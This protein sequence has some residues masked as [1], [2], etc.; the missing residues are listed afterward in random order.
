MVASSLRPGA[1]GQGARVVAGAP[2]H[3]AAG[4]EW[5]RGAAVLGAAGLPGAMYCGHR[6][7]LEGS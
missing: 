4:G 7:P 3:A 6:G 5:S 2:S 1:L